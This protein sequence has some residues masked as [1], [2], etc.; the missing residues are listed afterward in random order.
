MYIY[1]CICVCIYIMVGV[2]LKRDG[3]QPVKLANF[4]RVVFAF[5]EPSQL[6]QVKNR[7]IQ[8]VFDAFARFIGL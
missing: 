7:E 6:T 4:P 3:M 8:A 5:I 1:V 2:Y